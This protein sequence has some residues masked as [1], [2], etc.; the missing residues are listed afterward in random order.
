[1]VHSL[2]QF[3]RPLSN[4]TLLHQK[5]IYNSP[6]CKNLPL[7]PQI[8]KIGTIVGDMMI[9]MR[10]LK[11]FT[12]LLHIFHGNMDLQTSGRLSKKSPYIVFK[13]ITDPVELHDVSRFLAQPELIKFN[14]Q[15]RVKMMEM[16]QCG[17]GISHIEHVA[18]G[19]SFIQKTVSH[20]SQVNAHNSERISENENEQTCLSLCCDRCD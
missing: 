11:K 7:L 10:R 3:T 15:I 20:M 12:I 9:A 14:E 6:R 17:F 1:M 4:L 18:F 19:T 8:N 13:E 2:H 16:I 5:Q